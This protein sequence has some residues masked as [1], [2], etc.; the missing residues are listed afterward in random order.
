MN[1]DRNIFWI[2]PIVIMA[3]GLLPMPYSFYS[4]SR[5]VV[6]ACSV[7]FAVQLF[8]KA[9]MTF[10]WVFGFLAVLYNPIVPVHLYD[11][12]IWIVINIVTSIIFF[13]KKSSI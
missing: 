4:L 7:Y 2:A 12:E 9:D 8:K 13:G 11:K 3:I 10:V 5:I 1:V 6:S